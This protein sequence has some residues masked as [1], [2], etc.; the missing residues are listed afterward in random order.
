M[1]KFGC[2]TAAEF[3][4]HDLKAEIARLTEVNARLC[5]L[6]DRALEQSAR[7]HPDFADDIRAA[8]AHARG[9]S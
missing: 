6:L 2:T 9:Q 8:L 3:V 1:D 5:A 7:V 4:V